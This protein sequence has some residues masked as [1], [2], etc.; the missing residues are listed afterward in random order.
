[1]PQKL[2]NWQDEETN[3]HTLFMNC[4]DFI[5]LGKNTGIR[6]I[7]WTIWQKKPKL[8]RNSISLSSFKADGPCNEHHLNA[9]WFMLR[10]KIY[11]KTRERNGQRKA[12]NIHIKKKGRKVNVVMNNEGK[13]NFMCPFRVS[14]RILKTLN[15]LGIVPNCAIFFS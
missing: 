8:I 3:S 13:N 2:R 15:Y 5:R 9:V 1:M 6:K 14:I 10:V 4:D 12:A 7:C 11:S